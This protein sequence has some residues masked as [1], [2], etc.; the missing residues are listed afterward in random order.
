MRKSMLTL[1]LGL[2]PILLSSSVVLALP[3]LD[4]ADVSASISIINS[5]FGPLNFKVKV[6]SSIETDP[7]TNKTI[8][9]DRYDIG[10]TLDWTELFDLNSS[11]VLDTSTKAS[12]YYVRFYDNRS[13]AYKD[14][15]QRLFKDVWQN[16]PRSAEDVVNKMRDGE[17]YSIPVRI[18]NRIGFGQSNSDNNGSYDLNSNA[19]IVG[20]SV[21][22]SYTLQIY[23][24]NQASVRV[25][26]VEL[27]KTSYSLGGSV[28][29]NFGNN[30]LDRLYNAKLFA[31]GWSRTHKEQR[32]VLDYKFDLTNKEAR[33]AFDKIIRPADKLKAVLKDATSNGN[34]LDGKTEKKIAEFITNSSATRAEEISIEDKCKQARRVERIFKGDTDSIYGRDFNLNVGAIIASYANIQSTSIYNIESINSDG[35]AEDYTASNDTNSSNRTLGRRLFHYDDKLTTSLYTLSKTDDQ[36]NITSKAVGFSYLLKDTKMS[37]REQKKSLEL[38]KRQA[39]QSVYEYSGAASNPEWVNPT[40]S[41]EGARINSFILINEQGMQ[42]LKEITANM[43]E[44]QFVLKFYNH[45]NFKSISAYQKDFMQALYSC[46]KDECAIFGTDKKSDPVGG[47]AILAKNYPQIHEYGMGFLIDLIQSHITDPEKNLSEYVYLFLDFE[48]KEIDRRN[49]IIYGKQNN[50]NIQTQ[51]NR[52]RGTLFSDLFDMDVFVNY[53]NSPNQN[54]CN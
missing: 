36:Y 33:D 40:Q 15:V 53:T 16:F 7:L 27:S 39:S 49:P 4:T 43:T 34:I 44:E 3:S 19:E 25:R 37:K 50:V 23:K 29:A 46:V 41:R 2:I 1:K 5:N 24:Q 30:I 17:L 21:V 45:E 22:S 54:V 26:L 6:D 20:K 13:E 14:E 52:L 51:F 12:V 48:A 11:I 10:G 8:K 18:T 9:V 47:W 28:Q 31:L 35:T 38:F 32:F 42:K